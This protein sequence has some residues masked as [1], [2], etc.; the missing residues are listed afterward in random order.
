MVISNDISSSEPGYIIAAVVLY[1][2]LVALY[3]ARKAGK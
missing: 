3:A 2:C 1:C